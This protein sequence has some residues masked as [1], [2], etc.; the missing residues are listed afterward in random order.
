MKKLF[1]ILLTLLSF[2]CATVDVDENVQKQNSSGVSLASG[3]QAKP[4]KNAKNTEDEIPPPPEIII[5]ERPYFIPEKETPRSPAASG[6]DAVRNSNNSGIVKP[7]DYSHA[8]VFY[9]YNP[10]WVYEVYAMPLR[11]CDICLEPG[12]RALDV[13]FVSDSER[14]LV[15]A[16]V[17]LENGASVQHIYVKPAASGQEASL[18]INTD[19]RV[20][21]IILRSYNSV[22]MP[23]VRWRYHSGLPNNYISEPSFQQTDSASPA[24]KSESSSNANPFAGVDP[25]YLSFNYRITYG[26]FSKP[27]WLPE[28]VFDDGSKTYITFPDNVLQRELP[29]VFENRKDVLNYR[30]T[31]KLI[32]IDKLVENITVKIGKKE[33]TIA[34]KRG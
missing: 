7:Q 21:R 32:V 33:I 5:V 2:S 25:R 27:V 14:W 18:I 15:G 20:Y 17:S 31:G 11:V 9:D 6:V 22:F 8:A 1:I 13:P 29:S 4:K 16:A 24:N 3:K 23:L 26:L 28:L 19:R 10:D 12:E 30:V 34:K